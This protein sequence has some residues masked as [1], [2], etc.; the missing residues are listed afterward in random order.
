M[1]I[2]S[3]ARFSRQ[4]RE[5]FIKETNNNNVKSNVVGPSGDFKKN[6][7]VINTL[8]IKYVEVLRLRFVVALPP[9]S[10]YRVKIVVLKQISILFLNIL[11]SIKLCFTNKQ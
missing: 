3:V 10:S 1:P 6:V 8:Y 7:K 11:S 4:R 5:R 9:P 2:P